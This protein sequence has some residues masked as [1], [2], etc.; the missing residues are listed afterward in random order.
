[1]P[2]SMSQIR[3]KENPFPG[4]FVSLFGIRFA[5]NEKD[6]TG[7]LKFNALKTKIH[8]LYTNT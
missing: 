3:Q 4:S 6:F 8:V 2:Q 5:D 1:M 7:L